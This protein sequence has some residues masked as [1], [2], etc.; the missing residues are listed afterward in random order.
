MGRNPKNGTTLTIK[1]GE[2]RALA[3]FGRRATIWLV[4]WEAGWGY[5]WRDMVLR[6]GIWVVEV[7]GWGWAGERGSSWAGWLAGQG[8]SWALGRPGE[9]G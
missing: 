7:W 5:G 2:S 6:V 8:S 9:S 4:I 3:Q 1:L